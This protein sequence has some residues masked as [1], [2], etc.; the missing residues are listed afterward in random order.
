MVSVK[1]SPHVTQGQRVSVRR[2][3]SLCLMDSI[4]PRPGP[5]TCLGCRRD[6]ASITLNRVS[7]RADRASVSAGEEA[8]TIRQLIVVGEE[9][10]YLLREEIDTVLPPAT[11]ASL[12]DLLSQS[13]DAGIDIDSESLER[14]RTHHA[15]PGK[16]TDEADLTPIRSDTSSDIVRVY[17]A[18][19]SQVPLLTRGKEVALAKRIERGYRTVMVAISHTPSLVQQ[20]IRLTDA[21]GQSAN[22]AEIA[23][24]IKRALSAPIS[25]TPSVG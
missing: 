7:S 22:R 12:D 13:R 17:L 24:L 15:R 9:K 20:V 11:S 25:S 1:S 21:L 18:D 8:E 16:D 23:D 2:C 10:G 6:G 5:G 14:E 3:H 4:S 19:M